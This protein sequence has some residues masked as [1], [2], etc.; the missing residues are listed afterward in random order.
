MLKI[1]LSLACICDPLG[2]DYCD[3]TNG[4]CQCHPHVI[5]AKCDRCEIDHYGFD[6][7]RGCTACECGI[8]SNSTQCDDHSGECR[9]KPGVTGRQCDQCLPGYWNYSSEGC[10]RKFKY[11]ENS[12]FESHLINS[13]HL[14]SVFV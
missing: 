3:R 11:A 9:C 10:L 7:G 5:G 6:S 12:L 14:L 13:F 1:F 2:M 4:T 8:A